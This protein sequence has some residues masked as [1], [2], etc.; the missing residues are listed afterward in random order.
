MG[1]EM[2]RRSRNAGALSLFATLLAISACGSSNDDDEAGGGGLPTTPPTQIDVL[3]GEGFKDP[4]DAVVHHEG[5]EVYF[6]A[7]TLD[8]PALAA[9]FRV[10]IEGGTP[11]PLHAG[12]PLA[13]PSGLVLSCDSATLWVAEQ[14]PTPDDTESEDGMIYTLSTGGGVPAPFT[15][16]G[17]A[18]PVGLALSVDCQTLY[19]TGR[20][21]EGTPA[22]FTVPAVGGSASILYSGD[23][24]ISPGGVHVDADGIAWVM[25]HLGAGNEGEGALFS[26]D[27]SGKIAPVLGNLKGGVTMGVSLVAGGITAVIPTINES[28]KAEL[29]TAST[30][31]GEVTRIPAPGIFDPGG[32]RTARN[33]GVLAIT[34]HD[35]NAIHIAK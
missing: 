13:F 27:P 16:S 3:T 9:V 1:E 29:A 33:A 34:D 23:P 5:R 8:D 14:A 11:T 17:I 30:V 22:V 35:G 20:T 31:T 24:L 15:A 12:A 6:S 25:D 32:V 10:P 28:G 7:S 21:P 26:I 2:N 4:L 19:V 18:V